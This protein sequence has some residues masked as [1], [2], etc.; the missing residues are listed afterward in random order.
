M[1][2]DQLS[3][4]VIEFDVQ[5]GQLIREFEL[6]EGTTGLSTNWS[7][8]ALSPDGP[9]LVAELYE[10]GPGEGIS[11]TGH[12]YGWD[13]TTGDLVFKS[14]ELAS[15]QPYIPHWI[16]FSEDSQ[17]ILMTVNEGI[18]HLLDAHTGDYIRTYG[19][20]ATFDAP[21][22]WGFFTP[23]GILIVIGNGRAIASWRGEKARYSQ[24]KRTLP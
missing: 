1:S 3:G 5:T 4:A 9:L 8:V 19:E 13:V 2:S 24:Q 6:P 14:G 21:N 10:T 20:A 7:Q 15:K 12:L 16:E 23:V 22:V 11:K 17:Q 18:A